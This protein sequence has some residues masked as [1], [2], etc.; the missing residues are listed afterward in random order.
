MKLKDETLIGDKGLKI[1]ESLKTWISLARAVYADKDIIFMDNFLTALAPH[2]RRKILE[3][4]IIWFF[5]GKTRIIVPYSF[6]C[7]PCVDRIV[8]IDKG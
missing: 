5:H 6:H 8:A 2:V 4:I 3:D 1:N 7:L